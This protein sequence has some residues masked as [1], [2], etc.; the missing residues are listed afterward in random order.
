MSDKFCPFSRGTITH[1][2]SR[3]KYME[4]G[5]SYCETAQ[6]RFGGNRLDG[7][8]IASGCTC[9][10]NRCA[11]WVQFGTKIGFCGMIGAGARQMMKGE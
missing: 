10:E 1:F 8:A 7:G 11:V 4:T 3:T 9:L 2:N 5:Q 6:E